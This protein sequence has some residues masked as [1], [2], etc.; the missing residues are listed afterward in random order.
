MGADM[1][2][3]QLQ[4]A[5]AGAVALLA[6][7]L[8]WFLIPKTSGGADSALL[9]PDDADVVAMGRRI[10]TE[11]CAECHGARLEGEPNWQT[12]DVEGFMPAPPHDETGH[13]WHHPDQVLFDITRH[14]VQ[15]FAGADYQTKMPAYDKILSDHEIVAVLS[16]IKSRWPAKIRSGH[17][18]VNAN[19]RR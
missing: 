8:G 5:A 6:L 2:R 12:R 15:K 7:G 18:Q 13:T 9:R 1:T 19:A 14:G 17:D 3:R 11:T 16:Y 4:M 10:Y